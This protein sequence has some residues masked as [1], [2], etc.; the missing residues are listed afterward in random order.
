MKQIELTYGEEIEEVLR[1][2]F[3]DQNKTQKEIATELH[4]SYLT[5]IRWLRASGVRSR[6]LTLGD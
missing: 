2:L 4:I 1:I 5:V 3:V 6:R